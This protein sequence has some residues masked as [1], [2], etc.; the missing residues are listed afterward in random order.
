MAYSG[1][2][3]GVRGTSGLACGSAATH[4]VNA[5]ARGSGKTLARYSDRLSSPSDS[6]WSHWVNNPTWMVATRLA[7][8]SSRDASTRAEEAWLK[9]IDIIPLHLLDWNADHAA[10]IVV[11]DRTITTTQSR[12]PA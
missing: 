11:S 10:R 2:A 7:S 1:I 4:A 3:N 9:E 12:Q 6:A 5:L 8:P